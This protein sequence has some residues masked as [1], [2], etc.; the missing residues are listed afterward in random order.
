A[1]EA[2]EGAQHNLDGGYFS[3]AA[4]RAYYA[5]FYAASALLLTR[6]LTRS[7]HSGVL[8]AFRQHFVKPGL[9]EVEFSDAYGEAYDLRLIADYE[10]V[11]TADEAQAREVLHNAHRF[12]ARVADYLAEVGY[13]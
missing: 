11:G 2:L 12:V 4:N 13:S 5:F 7:K 6:D 3:I 1:Q 10:I 8:S 9:I